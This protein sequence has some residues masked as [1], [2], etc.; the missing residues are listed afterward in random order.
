MK[1]LLSS[2]IGLVLSVSVSAESLLEG[3]VRLYSGLPVA[4][5]QGAAI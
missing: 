5:A 1:T 4:G 3:Q 2:V